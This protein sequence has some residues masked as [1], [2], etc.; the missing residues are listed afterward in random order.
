MQPYARE[1]LD[2]VLTLAPQ[3]QRH[4][5]RLNLSIQSL[6]HLPRRTKFPA[7]RVIDEDVIAVRA[8]LVL[9]I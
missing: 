4:R 7:H 8:E 5:Q 1:G 6:R 2:R 9:A 3:T